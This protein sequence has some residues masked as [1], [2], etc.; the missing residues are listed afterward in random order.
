MASASSS[1]SS[2]LHLRHLSSSSSSSYHPNPS[3]H[4]CKHS[5]AVIL[6]FLFLFLILFSSTFLIFS[7]LS[8]LFHFLSFFL[9]SIS[10][11]ISFSYP[12]R[13]LSYLLPSFSF[14]YLFRSLY[15]TAATPITFLLLLVLLLLVLVIL[16]VGLSF[17]ATRARSRRR[18]GN[19]Y[20]EGLKQAPELDILLQSEDDIR[21]F[22]P[23]AAWRAIEQLPW[24]GGQG[25]NN[26]DY[27]CLRAELRR[28]VPPNGRAVM[29][30]RLSCGCAVS[31]LVAW[32]RKRP[33]RTRE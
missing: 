5:P 25:G 18:C 6:D 14:S 11:S 26:P 20:C 19:P 16:F 15:L 31:K 9:P 12:F 17:V 21:N 2:S 3:S 4:T 23:D 8:Y 29:L 27:E 28:R 10:I 1:S 22:S 32:G 24:M 13:S 7:F 33:R 30:C